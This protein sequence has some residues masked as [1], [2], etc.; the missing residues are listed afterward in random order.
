M[1]QIGEI[2]YYGRCASD[3]IRESNHE[4]GKMEAEMNV[5]ELGSFKYGRQKARDKEVESLVDLGCDIYTPPKTF[6]PQKASP[7]GHTPCP[8]NSWLVYCLLWK[9]LHLGKDFYFLIKYSVCL[10]ACAVKIVVSVLLV[11]VYCRIMSFLFTYLG[12]LIGENPRCEK[13]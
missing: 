6:A 13:T 11:F 10:E 12:V 9:R 4:S 8:N 3:E 2:F 7:K 1:H 5:E